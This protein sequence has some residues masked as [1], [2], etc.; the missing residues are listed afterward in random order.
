MSPRWFMALVAPNLSPAIPSNQ[1]WHK[2]TSC[3]LKLAYP[4]FIKH[5]SAPAVLHPKDSEKQCISKMLNQSTEMLKKILNLKVQ[6]QTWKKLNIV[7]IDVALSA[8]TSY[9]RITTFCLYKKRF[10][11]NCPSRKQCNRSELDFI[12]SASFSELGL[13]KLSST[14]S[15]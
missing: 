12:S 3:I 9:E 5:F 11:K 8:P 1:K 10:S 13:T 6:E 14:A 4:M 15:E 7:E 2:E